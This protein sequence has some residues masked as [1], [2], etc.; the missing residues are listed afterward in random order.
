MFNNTIDSK[1]TF[2]D[3]NGTEVLDLT[4]SIFKDDKSH[5]TLGSI[6]RVSRQY[7][8]RPDLIS[9]AMYGSDD[10]TEFVLK[11]S[12][13]DN[14]FSIN[15]DDIIFAASL[16]VIDAPVDNS[17]QNDAIINTIDY[18]KNYH[19]YID[20]AKVPSSSGSEVNTVETNKEANMS[21]E[22]DSGLH[23]VNGRIYF[24]DVPSS[25]S[26]DGITDVSTVTTTECAES[27]TTLGKFLTTVL[28]ANK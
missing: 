16:S 8:M 25:I 19:K 13:I 3:D 18:V 4:K 23:I 21:Y 7:C 24:G 9:Y 2:I 6:F 12:E 27:G 22:P 11:Y 20:P 10:Y 17:M 14:P 15:T 5:P 26:T 28:K 1:P